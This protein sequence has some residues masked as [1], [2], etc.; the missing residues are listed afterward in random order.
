MSKSRDIGDSAA[1]INFIDSLTSNAQTQLNAKQASDAQLTDIAGLTPSDSNFIVGNGSN[2]ITE[3]GATARTSLG[4]S[5]GSDVQAYDSNL[6]SFVGTFTLPTSDGTADQVL[7]TN[8]SGTIAFADAGGGGGQ[9]D[10]T[11]GEALAQGDALFY[12]SSNQVTKLVTSILSTISLGSETNS[13]QTMSLGRPTLLVYAGTNKFIMMYRSSGIPKARAIGYDPSADNYTFGSEHTIN[14]GSISSNRNTMKA[15]YNP[16][17]DTVVLVWSSTDNYPRKAI[18]TVSSSLSISSSASYAGGSGDGGSACDVACD[19]STGRIAAVFY[20]TTQQESRVLC[21]TNASGTTITG[22]Q[23]DNATN[24]GAA[25]GV[26]IAYDKTNNLFHVLSVYNNV[27]SLVK[28]SYDGTNAPT[29][30][31]VKSITAS[32]SYNGDK[33]DNNMYSNSYANMVWHEATGTLIMLAGPT[34][35]SYYFVA[36]DYDNSAYTYTNTMQYAMTGFNS[37]YYA[38]GYSDST[39]IIA[40]LND[41]KFFTIAGPYT[42][43]NSWDGT[44]IT[45]VAN[46]TGTAGYNDY[47]AYDPGN[48]RLHKARATSSNLWMRNTLVA[49]TNS[50]LFVGFASAATSSGATCTVNTTGSIDPNRTGLTAG[51]KYFISTQGALDTTDTGTLAGKALTATKL[52]VN[53]T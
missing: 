14:T 50:S 36:L 4:V 7:T 9:L 43:M 23:Q 13:T 25:G 2:F 42:A 26:R 33:I 20:G 53:V 22:E 19:P 11:A 31:S 27:G 30:G 34:S 51:T 35:S 49:G 46:Q 18:L 41:N 45:Q 37:N 17:A 48:F 40:P 47:M 12:N 5:I 3:S 1:T 32:G 39:N 10:I 21:F 24:D 15:V 29:I 52:L 38:G 8:G 6:T 28:V 16:K 44:N